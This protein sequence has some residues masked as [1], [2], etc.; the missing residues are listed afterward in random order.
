[1]DRASLEKHTNQLS[2]S[3]QLLVEKLQADKLRTLSPV[4]IVNIISD[5][6]TTLTVNKIDSRLRY[7]LIYI[8]HD[9]F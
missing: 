2:K 7:G 4:E 1:M 3:N 9:P 6:K 5:D 8:T